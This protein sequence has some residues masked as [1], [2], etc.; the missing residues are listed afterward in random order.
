M[1][2]SVKLLGYAKNVTKIVTGCLRTVKVA[3]FAL[4]DYKVV[5]LNSE[6]Y[7]TLSLNKTAG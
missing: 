1:R 2:I 4:G 7:G 3:K 5:L 6:K